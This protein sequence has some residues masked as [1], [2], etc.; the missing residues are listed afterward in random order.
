MTTEPRIAVF[1]G[2]HAAFAHAADLTL[3]GFEVSLCE[4]PDLADNIAPVQARGGIISEPTPST[5]L[6]PGF[7]RLELVT[8]DAE[9][10]LADA[11][12]IFL[13]VPAFAHAAF[14]R[15]MARHLRPEQMV[16]LSP[17]SFGG[18]VT[19]SQAL[20]SHGCLALPRLVEAQSMMYACRKSGPASVSISGV[21]EGLRMAVFPACHTDETMDVLLGIFPT[22]HRAP[23]ILWTWLSNPNPIGHPPITILNAGWT[24][25]TGGD[26]LFYLEGGTPSVFKVVEAL[27]AERMAIGAAWGLELE[28]HEDLPEIWYGHQA[29]RA[30]TGQ[31][32]RQ[33]VYA[34]IKAESS[35]DSR[36]LTEDLPFGLVPWEDMAHM[37]GVETP[38]ISGLIDLGNVLLDRDFRAEGLT[39]SRI[40][41]GG[42]SPS[43]LMR[44]A[45][46]GELL[47]RV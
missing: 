28:A 45:E 5:G 18:A 34:T 8:T 14:A 33:V 31:T 15:Q 3:R 39:L 27:D 37:V 11:Q 2:G 17:A 47:A 7:A 41:L 43:Q 4:L 30:G 22:L 12:V 44:M 21:K 19:F 1:G 35:L 25:Q 10:A 13:V 24:E 20:L 26:F 23:N 40:G 32:P 6:T 36:Y 29:R 9:L 38:L 16:V 46:E 42:L